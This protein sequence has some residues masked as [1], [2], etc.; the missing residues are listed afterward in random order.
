MLSII[1]LKLEKK[2]SAGRPAAAGRHINRLRA[3]PPYGWY[4]NIYLRMCMYICVYIIYCNAI[5]I[6]IYMAVSILFRSTARRHD[7]HGRGS[8]SRRGKS[9]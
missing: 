5:Y 2:G 9:G 4:K 7:L 3:L 8:G 1:G 6:Y